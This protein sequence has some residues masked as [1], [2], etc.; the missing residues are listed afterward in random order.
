MDRPDA[1]S[2]GEPPRAQCRAV[3]LEKLPNARFR[4]R[5]EDGREVTAS[6]A[7]NLRMAYVRLVAGT[8]VTIETSPF[9]PTWARI[10]AL[11]GP[12]ARP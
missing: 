5:A 9:D 12:E 4:L 11:T 2:G 7:G 10:T 8:T 6:V 3:V 1:T